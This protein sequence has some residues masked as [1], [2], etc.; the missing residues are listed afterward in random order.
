[1]AGFKWT[2]NKKSCRKLL[3][4]EVDRIHNRTVSELSAGEEVDGVCQ[5]APGKMCPEGTYATTKR[6]FYLF[7]GA[8]VWAS[9]ALICKFTLVP[10]ATTIG[11]ALGGPGGAAAGA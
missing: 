2:K 5:E 4:K 7:R 1:M 8:A 3:K 6:R 9:A 11:G 10:L